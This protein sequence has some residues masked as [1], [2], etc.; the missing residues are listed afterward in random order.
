[1]EDYFAYWSKEQQV[2]EVVAK[3]GRSVQDCQGD[4]WE[5]VYGGDAAG[6]ALAEGFE[7]KILEEILSEC[8]ARCMR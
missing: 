3:L 5:H 8:L 2:W 7:W 1:M 4:L 6:K